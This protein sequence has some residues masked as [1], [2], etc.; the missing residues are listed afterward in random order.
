LSDYYTPTTTPKQSSRNASPFHTPYAT[1]AHTILTM[2]H[3]VFRQTAPPW[4]PF[5]LPHSLIDMAT[6][7][8][9]VPMF[10]ISSIFHRSFSFFFHDPQSTIHVLTPS[11]L[12]TTQFATHI[13]DHHS[14][15]TA[16]RTLSCSLLCLPTSFHQS[17]L[18][19][20]MRHF[21]F[22]FLYDFFHQTKTTKKQ[23]S[24]C[25]NALIPSP[26]GSSILTTSP[27]SIISSSLPHHYTPDTESISSSLPH[28]YTVRKLTPNFHPLVAFLALSVLIGL[29]FFI[30]HGR[31][32]FPLPDQTM[33][34]APTTTTTDPSPTDSSLQT[35]LHRPQ[36]SSS[37]TQQTPTPGNA[38]M[39]PDR[40]VT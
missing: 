6:F 25:I 37:Q 2:H 30:T 3:D 14:M 11:A 16:P 31:S 26:T 15:I 23:S 29:S 17:H 28:H 20:S 32:K 12:F 19:D 39:G 5:H 1:V 33:P 18:S 7:A 10:S 36:A 8:N 22:A 40:E 34:D 9:A 35:A 13:P 38:Q 4:F 27:I 21:H 24:T